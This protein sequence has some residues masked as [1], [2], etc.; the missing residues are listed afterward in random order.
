[1]RNRERA[2]IVCVVV[3]FFLLV[4][5]DRFVQ[6]EYKNPS[7]I[8]FG[9]IFVVILIIIPGRYRPKASNSLPILL[10][11]VLSG[12]IGCLMIKG[13][14]G[15]SAYISYIISV[16]LAFAVA[17]LYFRFRG[18]R[19]LLLTLSFIILFS[20][21]L[22]LLWKLPE[23][24]SKWR[25]YRVDKISP[26]EIVWSYRGEEISLEEIMGSYRGEEISLEEIMGSYRDKQISLE[27]IVWS[28]RDKQISVD[29]IVWSYQ[30]TQISLDEIVWSYQD[31]QI[32]VDEI[33]WSYQ[34]DRISSDEIKSFYW[35]MISAVLMGLLS[36]SITFIGALCPPEEDYKIRKEQERGIQQLLTSVTLLSFLVA[37]FVFFLSY[38]RGDDSPLL[39]QAILPIGSG[40]V[41]ILSYNY[42]KLF[43]LKNTKNNNSEHRNFSFLLSGLIISFI[44]GFIFSNLAFEFRLPSLGENY[45]YLY[46]LMWSFWVLI[47]SYFVLLDTKGTDEEGENIKAWDPSKYFEAIERWINRESKYIKKIKRWINRV[48]Y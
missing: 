48:W 20:F 6:V 7:L 13:T 16:S 32:S 1:M 25:S 28:Y 4:V 8:L 10:I 31:T 24:D 21:F 35:G 23:T 26:D 41:P 47:A 40:L 38:N 15:E 45:P 44:L 43:S 5:I 19:I 11:L 42:G 30:D 39:I 37:F 12:V 9:L 3:F 14:R 22:V 27:E 18:R 2:S 46:L 17:F 29:E 36:S 34:V 33:V